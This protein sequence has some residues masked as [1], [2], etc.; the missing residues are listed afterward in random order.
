MSWTHGLI[1][2]V[3]GIL[4]GAL[5]A[6]AGGGGFITL[7]AL[8]F[9]GATPIRANIGGTIAVWPGLVASFYA[10]RRHLQSQKHPL[11][12]YILLGFT[13][14]IIGALLLLHTTNAFFMAMLPYLLL[15]ATLLFV[16]G[17]DLTAKWMAK[18]GTSKKIP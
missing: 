15:F 12:I 13:G 5:N 6:L 2:F 1:L 8:I 17:R 4:A 18:R 11:K 9:A 16:F 14:A 7:P 10:Y 3:A